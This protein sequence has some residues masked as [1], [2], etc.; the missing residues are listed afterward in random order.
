[1]FKTLGAAVVLALSCGAAAAAP[2]SCLTQRDLPADQ[3][4]EKAIRECPTVPTLSEWGM[5][6]LGGVLVVLAARRLRRKS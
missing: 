1:M 3:V 6:G 5:A 4:G 2:F